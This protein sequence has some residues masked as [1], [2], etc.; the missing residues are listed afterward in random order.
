MTVLH[1]YN[2]PQNGSFTARI[3]ASEALQPTTTL[4]D[5]STET[6]TF[7]LPMEQKCV[8]YPSNCSVDASTWGWVSETSFDRNTTIAGTVRQKDP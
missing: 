2:K 5:C 7:Y 3:D 4:A 8:Q 6:V 1:V